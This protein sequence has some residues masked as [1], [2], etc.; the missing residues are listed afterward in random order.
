MG[1]S[2]SATETQQKLDDAMDEDV[3][4]DA[5]TKRN[6]DE[7]ELDEGRKKDHSTRTQDRA[8]PKDTKGE[9][10]ATKKAKVSDAQEKNDEITH[11][12]ANLIAEPT[13][14]ILEPEATLPILVVGKKRFPDSSKG[15]RE[16]FW[17][18]V[19][20]VGKDSVKEKLGHAEG[21]LG[22]RNYFIKTRGMSI[23]HGSLRGVT[24]HYSPPIPKT[25]SQRAAHLIYFLTHPAEADLG[26]MQRELSIYSS[27]SQVRKSDFKSEP[28][29]CWVVAE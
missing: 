25:P 1:A 26:C 12:G 9:E 4:A 17:S 20:K 29:W 28:S 15:K 27:G 14:G 8:A 21:A 10:P 23:L 7:A 22:E 2:N 3:K 18:T 24:T 16:V 6:K 5:G 11:D 19:K 13:N